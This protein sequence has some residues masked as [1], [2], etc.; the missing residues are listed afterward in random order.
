MLSLSNRFCETFKGWK[1][2]ESLSS[3][4]RNFLRLYFRCIFKWLQQIAKI[5]ANFYIVSGHHFWS[6]NEI[7]MSN[8]EFHRVST[9]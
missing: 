7:S 2:M 9:F 1:S 5:S 8:H 3:L 4:L 6:K